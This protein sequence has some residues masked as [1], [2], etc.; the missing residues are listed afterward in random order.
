MLHDFFGKEIYKGEVYLKNDDTRVLPE[1][2]MKY[3]QD[4]Q[5]KELSRMIAIKD[6]EKLY[7]EAR[8]FLYEI[9]CELYSEKEL[10]D[11]FD[12]REVT[13]K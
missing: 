7:N 3:V 11:Y 4:Q 12:F 6:E 10:I 2:I 5:L 1:D 9:V 13:A 8:A